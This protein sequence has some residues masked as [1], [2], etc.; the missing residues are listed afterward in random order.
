MSRLISTGKFDDDCAHFHFVLDSLVMIRVTEIFSL[1]L[2]TKMHVV[3][4][5]DERVLHAEFGTGSRGQKRIGFNECMCVRRYGNGVGDGMGV[6][7]ARA[8]LLFHIIIAL[9]QQTN[10]H[11]KHTWSEPNAQPIRNAM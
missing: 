1:F 4:V 10:L 2:L 7:T 9:Y 5:V 6:D 11:T 3:G 8:L